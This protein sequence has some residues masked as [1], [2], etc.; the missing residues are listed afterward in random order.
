MYAAIFL[1]ESSS[2]SRMC[3]KKTV[4]RCSRTSASH[5]I[6]WRFRG[7]CTSSGNTRRRPHDPLATSA[8]K[9]P[10]HDCSWPGCAPPAPVFHLAKSPF[11]RGNHRQPRPGVAAAFL[12]VARRKT[13]R[14]S[15]RPD[16][17][18]PNESVMERKMRK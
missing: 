8:F 5:T 11:E 15:C 7:R 10:W 4:K 18:T 6:T 12:R 16:E 17:R 13:S 1:P 14:K 3:R 9:C 2:C